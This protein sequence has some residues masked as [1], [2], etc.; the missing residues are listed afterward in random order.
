MKNS[1][2]VDASIALKWVLNEIDSTTALAL[3]TD[4][5]KV[6]TII[7]APAL[8][9]YEITNT[10]YQSVRTN[11][12]TINTAKD[13]L[14]LITTTVE[15]DFSAPS[16]IHIRAMELAKQFNLSATYD[17]HYLALAE[18]VGCDLWTSDT[19][20]WRMV[21]EHLSWVRCLADY[22]PQTSG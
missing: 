16:T 6:G 2:I 3:L 11:R 13:S 17:A 12:I 1:I 10:L 21:K 18:R 7:R 4:W 19:R 14:N 9:A 5:N 22:H 15:L 8:L 20:M